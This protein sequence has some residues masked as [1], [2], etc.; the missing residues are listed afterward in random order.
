[1]DKDLLTD[2]KHK[3]IQVRKEIVK[4]THKATSGHPGGSLSSVEMLVYLYFKELRIDNKNPKW[5]VRD[6]FI[7]SKGHAAPALYAVLSM[8]GFFKKNELRTLRKIDSK[9]QGHPD[10]LLT[11]GVDMTTGSLGQGLSIANGMALGAKIIHEDFN[12]FVIIGDGECQEGMVWEA[13]MAASYHKLDNLFV[14]LDYNGIQLDGFVKDIMELQPIMDK[15]KSFGWWVREIDGHN[16]EEIESTLKDAKQKKTS[17]KMIIAHTIKGKGISFMEN[18]PQ[19]HGKAPN[20]EQLK[21][22]LKE[23]EEDERRIG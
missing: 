12:V 9:L 8:R 21:S 10:M 17:P 6:R 14:F 23:L 13:A 3:A 20:E 19:W 5:E 7:L 18:D 2:L 11:P 1:M 16:F 22:A 4:M 15:W